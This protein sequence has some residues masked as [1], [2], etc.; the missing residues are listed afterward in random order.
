MKLGLGRLGL[1]CLLMLS[2]GAV[3]GATTIGLTSGNSSITLNSAL[4]PAGPFLSNWLVDGTNVLFAEEFFYRVGPTGAEQNVRA[5][6]G[7]VSNT[8]SFGQVVY[9]GP[10]FTI[11]I[12]NSLL[13]GTVGSHMADLSQ[14]IR[15]VNTSQAALDF[16]LF[17]YT[18]F[19][20]PLFVNN[21]AALVNANLVHQG[22]SIYYNDTT[23]NPASSR[24][25]IATYPSTL[26]R[27]TDGIATTL[28]NTR[29][30][31]GD[32]TWALQ[33]DATIPVGANFF[34]SND[35]LIG[36]VPEPTTFAML[37]AGLVAFGLYR[38]RATRRP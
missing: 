7:A 25:E 13:G 16:H 3:L 29:S 18:D 4:T 12:N 23:F 31:S 30:A 22:G 1:V 36:A 34:T 17:H 11:T 20:I 38:R 28:N 14:A 19:D 6:P 21:I 2:F 15:V 8:A 10:G 5:L 35:Q 9:T 24:Y 37:G 26:L 32:A 33:W 27:L